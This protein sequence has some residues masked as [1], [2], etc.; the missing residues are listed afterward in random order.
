MKKIT[1]AILMLFLLVLGWVAA[2]LFKLTKEEKSLSLSNL[3]K[4]QNVANADVPPLPLGATGGG[5]C[6]N[7]STGS[8][9]Y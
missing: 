9:C 5:C 3:I 2:G 1:R 6:G 8:T 4:S 7:G